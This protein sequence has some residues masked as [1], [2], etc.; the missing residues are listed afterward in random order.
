MREEIKPSIPVGPDVESFLRTKLLAKWMRDVGQSET[1]GAN[2]SPMIDA[3]NR[4]MSEL[5]D[6]YCISG[7]LY[8]GVREI[9]QEYDL[10][11]P[12]VMTPSTQEFFDKTPSKYK[13]P[14]GGLA[15]KADIGIMKSR[16]N[17]SQGHAYGL[18]ED[19]V[20]G[21]DQQTVEYNTNTAGSRDG[22][23]VHSKTR[24]QDGDILKVYR[25]SVDVVRWIMDVN[26]DFMVPL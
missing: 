18:R 15:K 21:K 13:T 11:N 19:E 3:I 23:G 10:A 14:K 2:R 26:P 8:R 12:V 7:L 9:C 16:S 6:P 20:K 5:G 25:G 24:T 1:G 4:A 22:E 17:S